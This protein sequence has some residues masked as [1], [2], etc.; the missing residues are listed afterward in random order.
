MAVVR[1]QNE[2]FD[3]SEESRALIGARQDIGA[4]VSFSGLVRNES[5][6]RPLHRLHL[7]HYPGMTERQIIRIA[8]E[9]EQRFDLSAC[10]V[11]HRHGSLAPGEPIVL[12]LTAAPHRRDA[13]LAAEFLMDWLK[14]RAPFWKREDYG[15]GSDWVEARET[16]HQAAERWKERDPP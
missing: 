4:I 6:G 3:V 10:L 11:I 14:T 7:E 9:A 16:D 13:F 5:H 8:E 1:V 12:V 15:D 2:P